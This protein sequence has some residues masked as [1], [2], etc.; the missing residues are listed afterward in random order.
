MKVLLT[1]Q[2]IREKV[3]DLAIKINISEYVK[4]RDEGKRLPPIFI[5]VLNGAA[6]FF[7]DLVRELDFDLE[8]DFV[9]AKSYEGKDNSGGVKILKDIESDI[10][11]RD[12]YI[13]EDIIDSGETMRELFLHLTTKS[14]RSIKI[15]TLLT[16]KGCCQP[17]DYW[18]IE[19]GNEW[20][21]GYGLDDNKLK[22]NLP[23]IYDLK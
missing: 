15:V 23:D 7:T 17:K 11:D 13:V 14:P 20:V 12:V 5:C 21:V 8:L 22:R 3:I 16:R 18:G 9:R 6:V 10:M 4:T 1:E 19:I 2:V